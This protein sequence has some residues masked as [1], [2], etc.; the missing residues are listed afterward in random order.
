MRST[1][2]VRSPFPDMVSVPNCFAGV[3]VGGV[4]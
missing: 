4:V 3:R 2:K 1:L